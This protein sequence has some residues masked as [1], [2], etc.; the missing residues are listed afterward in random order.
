MVMTGL[1]SHGSC[2]HVHSTARV[3]VQGGGGL[4]RQPVPAMVVHSRTYLWIAVDVATG[5]LN[6]ATVAM[7]TA[8]SMLF[9][10]ELPWSIHQAITTGAPLWSTPTSLVVEPHFLDGGYCIIAILSA[11]R[12]TRYHMCRAVGED[13][14]AWNGLVAIFW[15]HPGDWIPGE[16]LRS[17]Q[18][19]LAVDVQLAFR[20]CLANGGRFSALRFEPG[21]QSGGS[22]SDGSGGN[23]GPWLSMVGNLHTLEQLTNLLAAAFAS[24]RVPQT[25]RSFTVVLHVHYSARPTERHLLYRPVW[26]ATMNSEDGARYLAVANWPFFFVWDGALAD[27]C[28]AGR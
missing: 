10:Q 18:L 2:A 20:H 19:K 22:G 8:L 13:L 1:R 3:Q 23:G 14:E 16:A 24:P 25:L 7:H 15:E 21:R 26:R 12:R 27:D 17:A 6:V 28:C 11:D 9:Q 5:N 4:Q